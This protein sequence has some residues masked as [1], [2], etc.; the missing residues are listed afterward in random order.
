MS[1]FRGKFVLLYFGYTYCPDVCP[2]TLAMLNKALTRADDIADQ[3]QVIFVSVDPNRDSP[4]RLAEYVGF[5]NPTFIGITGG[6]EEIDR[7]TQS[8]GIYYYLNDSESQE[9]YTVD[10]TSRIIL[11]DPEGNLRLLWSHETGDIDIA[12]DLKSLTRR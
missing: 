10:H 5:F 12:A 6:R 2:A 11:I 9:D 3:F 7:V 1:D 4:E 8:F